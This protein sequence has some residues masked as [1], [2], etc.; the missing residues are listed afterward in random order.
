MIGCT[1]RWV[2]YLARSGRLEPAVKLTGHTGAYVFDAAVVRMYLA[3]KRPRA[4]RRRRG[5][6]AITT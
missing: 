4:Q 6:D 1:P 5:R 3:H 2:Q